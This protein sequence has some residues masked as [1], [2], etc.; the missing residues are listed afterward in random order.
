VLTKHCW[1][2]FSGRWSGNDV[3]VQLFRQKASVQSKGFANDSLDLVSF[4]GL[5]DLFRYCY[6]EA[7]SF[8]PVVSGYDDKAI[9]VVTGPIFGYPL[10]FRRLSNPICLGEHVTVQRK[11]PFLLEFL[12][13]TSP[14]IPKRVF[15]KNLSGC[16][17]FATPRTAAVDNAPTRFR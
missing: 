17:P 14:L 6:S 5:P 3:D 8:D 1:P 4:Y 16:Q 15:I 10:I 11:R 7:R 13:D 2:D 12:G 9:T